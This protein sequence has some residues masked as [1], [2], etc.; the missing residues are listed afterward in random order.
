MLFSLL[1]APYPPVQ[2]AQTNVAMR[3]ERAH[4][5]FFSEGES[6]AIVV[7]RLADIKGIFARCD[8]AKEPKS[9][10]FVYSL[11]VLTGETQGA[12]CGGTGIRF[13]PGQQ[14]GFAQ[15]DGPLR[16]ALPVNEALNALLQEGNCVSSA[17]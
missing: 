2:F 12:L 5:E 10:R 8:L 6:L 3:D 4:A 7:F 1:S 9:V 14:I 16:F 17:P 15:P 13:P 11:F